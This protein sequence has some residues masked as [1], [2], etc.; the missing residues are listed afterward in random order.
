M[1]VLYAG[2]EVPTPKLPEPSMRTFS[3]PPAI[4]KHSSPRAPIPAGDV[5]VDVESRKRI[6]APVV[7]LSKVPKAACVELYTPKGVA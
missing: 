6:Y 1:C 4:M 2:S 5:C 3:E 7:L